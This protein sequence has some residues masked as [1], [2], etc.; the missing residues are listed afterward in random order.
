MSV[1]TLSVNG[2]EF[3]KMIQHPRKYTDPQQKS[4]NFPEHIGIIPR[5]YHQNA[6]QTF[7]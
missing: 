7:F 5:K 2:T 4:T 6:P 3:W 1:Y